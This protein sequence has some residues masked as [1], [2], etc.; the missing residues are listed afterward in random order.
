[1]KD[2]IIILQRVCPN[3][4]VSLFRELTKNTNFDIR[5]YIGDDLKNS[6]VKSANNLESIRYKRFKTKFI[7]LAGRILV[8]HVGLFRDLI[9]EKPKII[10]CEAESNILSYFKAIIYKTIISRNTRLIY[11]CYITLPGKDSKANI[12]SYYFKFFVRKLFDGFILYSSY[13]KEELLRQGIQEDKIFVATNVGDTNH[14]LAINKS[15]II[16]KGELRKKLHL[17]DIFTVLYVG[18]LDANKRPD[19][20][21]Q[22]AKHFNDGIAFVVLGSGQEYEYLLGLKQQS[23][24]RHFYLLGKITEN[25]GEYYRAADILLVPGRGGIAI[26]EALCFGLP[27]IV[28]EADGTEYDLVKKNSNGILLNENSISEFANAIEKLEKNRTL[29]SDM[30]IRALIQ[31]EG[32][33]NTINMVEV[34]INLISKF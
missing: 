33:Y 14:F 13:G 3:Y 8:L 1:M 30:G 10:I 2:K 22:L 27:V 23:G 32:E 29:T 12:L 24:L 6:K 4:R 31:M 19:I 25:L 34:F 15:I 26:S 20:M 18:T 17:P 7:N 9:K 28:H 5:L 21:Y 16:N 11:W